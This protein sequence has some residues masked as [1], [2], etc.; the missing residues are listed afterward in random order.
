MGTRT[1]YEPGTFSWVDMATT[2]TEAAKEFYTG[3]F[4]WETEDNQVPGGGVYIMCRIGGANVAAISTQPEQMAA[5]GLPPL[6]NSY[7]TVAGADEAAS[8]AKE[9]GGQ[10]ISEPFDVM[11]AGRMAVIADPAGAAL[12]VWEPRDQIG[13]GRVNDPGCLTWNDLS[14]SD[15]GAAERFY[16]DLFG[17][18]FEPVDTGGAPPYWT[19]AHGGGAAGRNG[20]MRE[21]APE[22]L[23]SGIPPHWMPYFTVESAARAADR[24]RELGGTLHFGPMELPT[25]AR[26]AVLGDP[27]GAIFAIFEGEVDD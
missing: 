5:Q 22:Q 20:G 1:R 14:T 23:E 8:R 27:Q 6:W 7:V 12:M 11:E 4:G 26:I 3:L 18:S 24:T 21:L 2:D 9:L 17:W 19:I 25:G 15:V 10:V 13:A 16:S